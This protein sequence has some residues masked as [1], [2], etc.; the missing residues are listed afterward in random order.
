MPV[1]PSNY[2]G[3]CPKCGK[4]VAGRIYC[5]E[6]CAK[7]YHS[8]KVRNH[9]DIK[10]Q[11]PKQSES[12]QPKRKYKSP[13]TDKEQL[14]INRQIDSKHSMPLE[15]KRYR[16]GDPGFE[17]IAKQITPIDKVP[18]HCFLLHGLPNADNLQRRAA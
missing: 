5:N 9:L 3:K 14:A 18:S 2:R 6:T 12:W 7:A 16:P 17:D 4:T 10:G 13:I 15:F 8:N 1:K 11:G